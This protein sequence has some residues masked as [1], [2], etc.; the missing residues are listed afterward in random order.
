MQRQGHWCFA[1]RLKKTP[2]GPAGVTSRVIDLR[3]DRRLTGLFP[4]PAGFPLLRQLFQFPRKVVE[5]IIE[6]QD[7][8]CRS[9]DFISIEEAP[10]AVQVG[11]NG[12]RDLESTLF[13]FDQGRLKRID[14]VPTPEAFIP[15]DRNF[16]VDGVDGV[17]IVFDS[18]FFEDVRITGVKAAF[19]FDFAELAAPG[20]VESVPMVEEEH[21]F[22]VV[23]AIRV[24]AISDAAFHAGHPGSDRL[25]ARRRDARTIIV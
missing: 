3:A 22:G 13:G 25:P 11:E 17:E 1:V 23:L 14:V 18:D 10:I 21:A 8:F 4:E 5:G 19:F 24:F 2:E 16:S 20:A 12:F 6:R 7:N 15:N 9:R